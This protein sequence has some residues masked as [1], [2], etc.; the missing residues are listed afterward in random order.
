MS[1]HDLHRSHEGVGLEARRQHQDVELVQ[2]TV[3]GA[4]PARLDPLDA[5]HDHFDVRSLD[6]VV[7]VAG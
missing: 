1:A 4:H 3:L 6:G 5:G 2:S 7:E